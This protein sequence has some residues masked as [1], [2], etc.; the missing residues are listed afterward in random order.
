MYLPTIEEAKK[1]SAEGEFGCIPI[2]RELFSDSRT[3]IEVLRALQQVS[4]HCFILESMDDSQRRGR[5]TI[6]GFDPVME[7]SCTDGRATIHKNGVTEI[8]DEPP[9]DIIRNILRDH[10]SPILDGFPKFTGGLVG[11]F[12]YDYVKYG[13]PTL[14]L[15]ADDPEDFKDM[16]LMLI[17]K[18]IVFDNLKQK[19][20]IIANV[21]TTNLDKDYPIALKEIDRMA[22]LIHRGSTGKPSESGLLSDFRPIHDKPRFCA[23]VEDVKHHIYE[24]DVFQVVL[25]NRFEAD[26]HG[27]LLDVY[28]VIRTTNPSPYMFFISGC[29]VEIAGASPETLVRLEEG[30]LRTFPLA[31]TRPRG[32]SSEE[33][34]RLEE[35]LLNDEKEL[36]EHN[37]LVDL[38]RNDLGKVCEFDSVKV[39]EHLTIES[40]SHVMHLG[41]T[42]VGRLGPTMDSIDALDAVLPAGTLSGAPKFRACEVIDRLE[43]NKRGIYGG[44][45][46]YLGL[47]GNMDVCIAI[48]IAFKK[49]GKV[50]VQSGAGVVA[51]SVAEKEYEEC[52][53]KSKAMVDAIHFADGGIQ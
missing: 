10:R 37:M 41:S 44:A 46:G 5:F 52:M 34:R 49:N 21:S 28:R 18:V 24:G 23:M 3:P 32:G 14:H 2:R 13:E 11:Y 1:I 25:S 43:G 31:G 39:E 9:A 26:Y 8:L 35:E 45:I 4:D 50:F 16:D 38:G 7:V 40:F 47:N 51:D 42:I 30:V 17:D 29:D 27:S 48:R 6:L 20:L 19:T 15:D 22:D 12:S 53:R 36:A 33:D